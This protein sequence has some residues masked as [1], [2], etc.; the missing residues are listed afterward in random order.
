MH[1][2]GHGVDEAELFE[3]VDLIHKEEKEAFAASIE[4]QARKNLSNCLTF[5]QTST[6][7]QFNAS[8][9]SRSQTLKLM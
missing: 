1:S 7:C 3:E 5:L 8:P 6:N 4:A 9:H 2:L